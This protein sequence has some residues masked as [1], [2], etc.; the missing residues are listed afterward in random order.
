MSTP[1]VRPF[2]CGN[3]KLFGSLSESVTLATGVR[4]GVADVNG[5]DVGVAPSFV[6]L[7]TVVQALKGSALRVA[8]Q[9]AHF[10]EKGA[11]TGEISMGQIADAGAGCV[12]LGHSERRTLF[13]ETDAMV[14][15]KTRAALAKGLLPIVCVGETLQER[16]GNQTLDVVGR[17]VDAAFLEIAAG[18][19]EKCVIAYEPVWAIGTGKTASPEQVQAVHAF[20]RS[21]IAAYDARIAGS[22]PLLYGGSVK[23]D[24][25]AALF[26]QADVD[27][28]L[29][30]GASLVA[31]DFNA[32]AAAA[33][34]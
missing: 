14:N 31:A 9:N 32:I 30:G 23:A 18:D 4:D 27:G 19:V 13:G 3:W 20:I 8:A 16:D 7:T 17:Q 34:P 25:A 1:H 21:E 2:F 15:K 28:G 5:A 22:L 33:A 24:N 29:I 6:A 11:F 10:E 26:S 12:I